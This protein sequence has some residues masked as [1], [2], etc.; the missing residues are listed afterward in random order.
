MEN[1]KVQE[2]NPTESLQIIRSMIDTAKNKLA[3]DG[4]F[5]IFW[6][7]LVFIA[8]LVNY[9]G[10]SFHQNASY[11][12]W[13]VLM[14]LGGVVSIIYGRKQAKK[15]KV[16]TYIE[17][18]LGYSWTAFIIAMAI[19][20]IFIPVHGVK[21]TYFFLMLLYGMA[22]LISGGLLNFKPLII[23]SIFSFACAIVSIFVGVNE[24][25][26]C[27]CVA[28][29]CSYIIPGHLLRSQYKSQVNV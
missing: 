8:A 9:I 1:K 17:T 7:W 10:V 25:F 2:M 29:L 6:G 22:T 13:P 24:Q 15:E 16:K 27:I 4:F 12:V 20:L 3:D 26:L 21:I 11:Y 23:G 14:P 18:Y 5:I 19:T 28:L